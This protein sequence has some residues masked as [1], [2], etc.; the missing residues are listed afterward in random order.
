MAVPY[1]RLSAFY[2]VYFA[3]FGSWLP[4]WPLYLQQLGYGAAAIG[5][6]TGM[7]Q[8][9]RIVGP[10]LW[11]WLAHRTGRRMAVIRG[12]ALAALIMFCGVF[13]RQDFLWLAIVVTGFTL[14]W[15]AMLAQFEVVTLAH[16]GTQAHRYSLIRVWGSLGFIAA[17]VG[18]GFIFDHIDISW[19][20]VILA[21]VLTGIVIASFA[22]A[23]VRRAGGSSGNAPGESW[24]TLLRHPPLLAFLG[25]CFLLQV[26][27]GPYYTF[28]SVYL[29]LYGYSRGAIGLLWALAVCAEVGLFLVM[30]RLLAAFAIRTLLLASLAL[31]TLRWLLTGLLADSLAILVVAQC[32]HAASFAAYHACAVELVRGFFSEARRGQGMALY[33][34]ISYGAGGGVGAVV[35]GLLWDWSPAVTF[36]FAAVAALLAWALV[37]GWIGRPG[38]QTTG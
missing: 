22:V 11:G 26:A 9:T 24:S 2:A 28:F 5:L 20:P 21:L 23:D 13:W 30:H 25:S 1:A 35:S 15:N 14:F 8:T 16:L 6:L 31:A 34:G 3:L 27:H 29:E 18:L 19:L 38:V 7:I 17:V 10:S 4:F 32:L 12:G 36:V 33:S 37:W